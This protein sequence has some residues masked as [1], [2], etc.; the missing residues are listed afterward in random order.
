MEAATAPGP[1]HRTSDWW[2]LVVPGLL[3]QVPLYVLHHEILPRQLVVV[4]EV[5]NQPNRSHT[6][7]NELKQNETITQ[8]GLDTKT[9]QPVAA[10][11]VFDATIG[12]HSLSTRSKVVLPSVLKYTVATRALHTGKRRKQTPAWAP[13]FRSTSVLNTTI[14][15][16]KLAHHLNR[17][18]ILCSRERCAH[19]A[20]RPRFL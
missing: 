20:H 3:L 9:S 2:V 17:G 1:F 19:R 16:T 14:K 18:Q 15:S 12:S 7:D 4:R 11:G 13:P 10:E 5:I 6:S 8:R